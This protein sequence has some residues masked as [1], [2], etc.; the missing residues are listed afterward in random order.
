MHMCLYLEDIVMMV[1]SKLSAIT[2]AILWAN[3]L[4]NEKHM[5]LKHFSCFCDLDLNLLDVLG[6]KKEHLHMVMKLHNANKI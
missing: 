2:A 6:I 5:R 4:K 3:I 1:R